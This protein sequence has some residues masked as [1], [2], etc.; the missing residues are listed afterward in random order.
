M[1]I[2]TF[3]DL[4]FEVSFILYTSCIP[5][6]AFVSQ[7]TS[8]VYALLYDKRETTYCVIFGVV[9]GQAA[10]INIRLAASN[11]VNDFD[12]YGPGYL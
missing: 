4:T 10:E 8:V 7:K 1:Q 3:C 6:H 11:M 2:L 12:Q 9:K 5:L